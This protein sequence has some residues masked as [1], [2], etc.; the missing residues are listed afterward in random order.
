M[1]QNFT[2]AILIEGTSEH[3][4]VEVS[5]SDTTEA[6]KKAEEIA[7]TKGVWRSFGGDSVFYPAHRIREVWLPAQK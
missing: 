2:L 5:A 1:P 7:S 4:G 6:Q 3:F